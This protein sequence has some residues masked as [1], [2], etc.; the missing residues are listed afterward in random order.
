MLKAIN[1]ISPQ[2][3]EVVYPFFYNGMDYQEISEI[4]NLDIQTVRNYM[5]LA[6]KK[7]E[8]SLK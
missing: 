1:L 5:S 4:M 3:R 8:K 2:K 6:L 7:C